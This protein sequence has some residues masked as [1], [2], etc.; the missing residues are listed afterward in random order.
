MLGWVITHPPTLSNN[1]GF[2]RFVGECGCESD[3]TDGG[4]GRVT[5][6]AVGSLPPSQARPGQVGRYQKQRWRCKADQLI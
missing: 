4:Q 1:A 2:V 5:A 6:Q 3:D